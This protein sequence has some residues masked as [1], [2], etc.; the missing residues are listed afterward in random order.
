[1]GG[2]E[3]RRRGIAPGGRQLAAAVA[4][5]LGVALVALVGLRAGITQGWLQGLG[6]RPGGGAPRTVLRVWDWWAPS[7][8]ETY[9][10]YFGELEREF[11]RLHPEVDVRYQFVPFSQYEQKMATGL[12]G[13]SPPDVFQS[14]VSF[15]EGFYDRGMLRP[16]NP[17]L[18]RERGERE[19]QRAA[20][21]RLD[22]GKI[23]DREA[24]LEAAWQHNTK[25][26][27]TVFGIPQILDASC[28]IWNLDLLQEAA[29]G[30]AEIRGMF[31]R[32]S[33]GSPDYERLRF[34][35]VRDWEQFRQVTRKLT[36]W[37][38]SGRPALDAKGDEL[39]TGFVI[40]AH[41]SGAGP[42]DPWCAANGGRFQDNDG[43]RALFAEPAGVEAM[44]FLVDLY[45]K[46]RVCPAFRR[47]LTDLDV[48]E[49]RRSA[50]VLSGTW[51]G[52]YLVRDT[53]GW[54][55]FGLAPFPPG[56][57]G[58]G[59][60]TLTWGNMLVISRR[61]A[62]PELAWEYIKFVA[63]LRGALRLLKHIEQN[64]PRKDFYETGA[65]AEA[66]R[67]LPYL[68]NIPAICESG[69][70]L[71]HTQVNAVDAAVRPIF[72]TILLRYPGIA[73]GRGPYPSVAAGLADAARK[74]DRVYA[75]YN[76]QVKTWRERSEE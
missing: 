62:Q 34:D 52:K 38:A 54:R 49:Q 50:C 44:Q 40:H 74:V 1:M 53:E 12:V 8:A 63:S 70:K 14:S 13:Q 45:W 5:L 23:V 22:T 69:K 2:R 28:L 4:I 75:R 35:A 11:E 24:F 42:F 17:F 46:D 41:G 66:C 26:D 27:G 15:A 55:H 61:A 60:A 7:T 6:P 16:L 21:E 10:R 31:E 29:Q 58:K 25:P 9:A 19:R 3:G 43:T 47:Q 64:S 57:S 33:D 76:A 37:D 67:R 32:R 48:F 71:R 68:A 65:W 18:E 59:P 73:A 30:D 51:A 56:P 36:R 20:G 72:E 39:Q